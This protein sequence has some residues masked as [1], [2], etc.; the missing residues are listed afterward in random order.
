MKKVN[1]TA[2]SN[3]AEILDL[4]DEESVL[5]KTPE[6]REFILSGID[7]FDAEVE[8]IGQNRELLEY[9]DERWREQESYTIDEVR[10]KLDL[11]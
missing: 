1:V 5:L 11:D 4:A 6:G 8:A 2:A 3:L 10:K 7:D 9:L